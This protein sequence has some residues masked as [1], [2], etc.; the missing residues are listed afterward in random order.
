M[1]KQFQEQERAHQQPPS[2]NESG[3]KAR[4]AAKKAASGGVNRGR[5]Q[6]PREGGEGE[7]SP[8]AASSSKQRGSHS[9]SRGSPAKGEEPIE[10]EEEEEEEPIEE[11]APEKHA[12]APTAAAAVPSLWQKP[13]EVSPPASPH[14]GS[15]SSVS[16]G[17]ESSSGKG[18]AGS[19]GGEARS[20]KA[21]SSSG[22]LNGSRQQ[23]AD[24]I[25]TAGLDS[26][27]I[28]AEASQGGSLDAAMLREAVASLEGGE[29]ARPLQS[30]EGAREESFGLCLPDFHVWCAEAFAGLSEDDFAECASELETAV[31]EA[32]SK[33]AQISLVMES[34]TKQEKEVAEEEVEAVGEAASGGGGGG[35]DGGGIDSEV[36]QVY[37]SLL[38]EAEH[39]AD[40]AEFTAM[41]RMGFLHVVRDEALGQPVVVILARNMNLD[42][43]EFSIALR[44]FVWMMDTIADGKYALI[45]LNAGASMDNVP[46]L[47]WMSEAKGVLPRKYRKN[48]TAFYVVEPSFMLKSTIGICTPFISSKFWK[49]LTFVDSISEL[50]NQ[51]SKVGY[52]C[53]LLL[54][55]PV[56]TPEAPSNTLTARR[57]KPGDEVA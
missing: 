5:E 20:G 42:D 27:T 28:D 10:L 29:W 40:A 19:K 22:V 43:V 33:S 14:L 55:M 1:L 53:H 47:S 46:P 37:A 41:M 3:S 17:S 34:Q 2:P 51:D 6:Q 12:P 50:F 15:V 4:A 16:M 45:Y 7:T 32:K 39:D 24:Q 23:W 49:K 48:M 18:D 21:P 25:F 38:Q 30:L 31:R 9:H 13:G 52:C 8:A 36:D 54:Q 57:P 35:G 44:F 26:T 56:S 11:D